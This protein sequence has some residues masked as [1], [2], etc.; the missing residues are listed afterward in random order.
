MKRA[1]ELRDLSE[2]HHH[3]LVQARRL[4]KA[5]SEEVVAGPVEIA[6]DF[7]AFWQEETSIHFQSHK[8]LSWQ[9]RCQ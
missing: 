5:A 3:G 7:L 4:K 8:L 1:A 2:D 6:K 9:E